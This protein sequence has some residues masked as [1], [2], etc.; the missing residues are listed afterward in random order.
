MKIVGKE[1][2]VV[3]RDREVQRVKRVTRSLLLA[4]IAVILGALGLAVLALSGALFSLASIFPII[5]LA[6]GLYVLYRELILNRLRKKRAYIELYKSMLQRPFETVYRNMDAENIRDAF[7]KGTGTFYILYREVDERNF[8]TMENE[9]EKR[10]GRISVVVKNV[11]KR[12]REAGA[13]LMEFLEGM[14]RSLGMAVDWT[15]AM[16][17]F[18][19][20][21]IEDELLDKSAFDMLKT[22]YKRISREVHA[23]KDGEFDLPLWEVVEDSV[24]AD[25][26]KKKFFRTVR[27]VALLAVIAG[28]DVPNRVKRDLRTAIEQER[29][30]LRIDDMRK[31][32]EMAKAAARRSWDEVD[33]IIEELEYQLRRMD[34]MRTRAAEVGA[35]R[36]LPEPRTIAEAIDTYFPDLPIEDRR[37]MTR[38]IEGMIENLADEMMAESVVSDEEIRATL[39]KGMERALRGFLPDT[40]VKRIVA[41]MDEFLR[42]SDVLRVIGEVLRERA[43]WIEGTEEAAGE[44]MREAGLETLRI[45]GR[46]TKR[47]FFSRLVDEA[48]KRMRGVEE[49]C[50]EIKDEEVRREM[51]KAKEEEKKEK[52]AK[53]GEKKKFEPLRD[54]ALT[55]RY[56]SRKLRGSSEITSDLVDKVRV[57]LIRV[58][59]LR[60]TLEA[61]RREEEIS[62]VVP[63]ESYRRKVMRII[64]DLCE[65]F[66]IEETARMLEEALRELSSQGTAGG[67]TQTQRGGDGARTLERLIDHI[68]SCVS[69][70]QDMLRI[71]SLPKEIEERLRDRDFRERVRMAF[72]TVAA[73]EREVVDA[74]NRLEKKDLRLYISRRLGNPLR[75]E[76]IRLTRGRVRRR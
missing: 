72:Q 39:I 6:L 58:N 32:K 10:R 28:I 21:R 30:L 13:K 31:E 63:D 42:S 16:S 14:L 12:I 4:L 49:K 22:Y 36:E 8:Y 47:K 73:L 27:K 44:A 23:I 62:R 29:V 54:L 1:V 52:G 69:D 34:D 5:P 40:Q 68:N 61:L 59:S 65:K 19:I 9:V 48:E 2:S 46:R 3:I 57:A 74:L 18:F 51:E 35:G 56:I 38:R 26:G 53:E 60:N 45:L 66:K 11:V 24:E 33:E 76:Y 71:L 25:G 41:R 15:T 7:T 70:L 50:S 67:G 75:R 17:G 64:D 37:E 20:A 43:D 55:A